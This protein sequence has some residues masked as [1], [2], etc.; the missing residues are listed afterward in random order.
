VTGKDGLDLLH[1]LC[2]QDLTSHVTPGR[3]TS[4]V[5]TNNKGRIVDHALIFERGDSLL[6]ISSPGRG[7]ILSDWVRRYVLTEQVALTDI[8]AEGGAFRVT[9][10]RA[11]SV[12]GALGG[13]PDLGSEP[14]RIAGVMIR[15]METTAIVE[16]A[17]ARPSILLMG[18]RPGVLDLFDAAVAEAV[19]AGGGPAGEQARQVLRVEDGL[20]E[21][22][23]ELT[24]DANPWEARL[25]SS[26]SL[27]KG[28]YVGQEVI[29][30]LNTYDKVSRTLVGL[31]MGRAVPPARGSTIRLGGRDVGV[32]TSAAES[33][34][35]AETI[36]LGYIREAHAEPGTAVR[37]LPAVPPGGEGVPATVVA[38]PVVP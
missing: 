31:K 37:I 7:S 2:T 19:K 23:A 30:R 14:H 22:G 34:A 21:A 11:A 3:G 38:L 10:P 20:P 29:A 32:L 15:G 8:S 9:G 5:F 17:G 1:R 27:T 26:I 25:D 18:E 6:L 24:E 28:C 12:L 33:L 13:L 16:S 4:A 35:A 36:G